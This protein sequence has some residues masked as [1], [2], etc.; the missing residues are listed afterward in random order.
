MKQ[1]E[2]KMLEVQKKQ[3]ELEAQAISNRI[4]SDVLIREELGRQAEELARAKVIPEDVLSRADLAETEFVSKKGNK[5]YKHEG[6][7]YDASGKEVSNKFIINA[8]EKGS[9]V[10]AKPVEADGKDIK[11]TS[12]MEEFNKI[13]KAVNDLLK[14]GKEPAAEPVEPTYV[15]VGD[16]DYDKPQGLYL[17]KDGTDIVSDLPGDKTQIKF[18]SKNPLKVPERLDVEHARG[19]GLTVPASSG[20]KALK[21]LIGDKE[22]SRLMKLSKK[23][24]LT[25]LSSKYPDV[26]W[27][28]FYDSYE[29]LEGYAGKLA[30]DKGYD[31]IIGD[32]DEVVILDKSI[33]EPTPLRSKNKQSG[34]QA[35]KSK[36]VE[37]SKPE[38]LTDAE[39]EAE[40]RAAIVFEGEKS[41]FFQ[42]EAKTF[43]FADLYKEKGELITE[44]VELYTGK[45]INDINRWY[46]GDGNIDIAAT[47]EML[48][49]FATRGNELREFFEDGTKHLEWMEMVSEAATWAGKLKRK[50][51]QVV[52]KPVTKLRK[53]GGGI[54]LHSGIDPTDIIK[55][56]KSVSDYVRKARAMKSFKPL[57]AAARIRRE[58]IRTLLD[59]SGNIRK[60]F[61][62]KLTDEG[63]RILQT[64]YLAKGASTRAAMNLK[65]MRKDVYR[66]LNGN[67]KRVLDTLILTDR[68]LDIAQYKTTKQF[69]FPKGMEPEKLAAYRELFGQIEKLSPERAAEIERR[70]A[71][72]FEWMKKPLQDMFEAGL[73]SEQE[74]ADLSA[75][76]YRKIKLV[77]IFDK[78]Y[79][80]KVGKKKRTVYDSG[81]EA[82]AHGRE[83]DIYEPSSEVMALEVFNRAYGR[84]MNNLANKELYNLA[85]E[86]PDNPFVKIRDKGKKNIPSGWI[87]IMLFE[88]GERKS[89]WLHPEVAKE[90]IISNP[91]M[92]YKMSQT[93]RYVSGSPVLRLFAT[94]INWGFAVANLPRDLMHAWFAARVYENG[95]WRSLYN[96]VAPVATGQLARDV[97][98]VFHDVVT[99]KG[100][101]EDYIN[102]GGGMEFLVHQGRLLQRGRHIEKPLDKFFN[103]MGWP[104]ETSELLTRLAIR[105]RA[106]RRGKSGKEA[107][108]AARDYM[109]FGQGGTVAKALDNGIPYL[110]AGIQ[111]MRGFWRALKDNPAEGIF[112]LAQFGTGVVGLYIAMQKMH[113]KT[114]EALKGNIDMQNNLCIPLGDDYA[115][116]DEYGQIRYPYFKIP[117][118]PSAKFFKKFFEASTDKWLGKEVDALEV[119]ST[120]KELS[121]VGTASLPPSISGV[122]GYWTNKDFWL[123]EDIWRETEKPFSWPASKEEYTP[124][125]PKFF[126]DVGKATGASPER[127]RYTIEELTTSGT[128]WSA[129]LGEAYEKMTE[130]VPREEKEKALAMRLAR[131]P[132]AKRFI[133]VTNPYSKHAEK[134]EKVNQEVT[135]KNFVVRRGLDTVVEGYLFKGTHTAKEVSEFIRSIPDPDMQKKM[136]DRRD[137][138]I[139]TNDLDNRSFWLRLQGMVPEARARI[140]LDEWNSA[141]EER[142]AELMQ[143]MRVVEGVGGVLTKSFWDE[144]DKFNLRQARGQ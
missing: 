12:N 28:K 43:Q 79:A 39:I 109:D 2:M 141:N 139:A 16:I 55:A 121:P 84:I 36:P 41:P 5:Y 131:M 120:L 3:L 98:S 33:V 102:E 35:P 63:Y 49:K 138:Q 110:N 92:S 115:F 83:T 116:E 22:F 105:E 54:T 135:V 103:F 29:M 93:V 87:R 20:I 90:W 14:E 107:T 58:G 101:Y 78:R 86:H 76:N 1:A 104:G 67:E 69:K 82:L 126:I 75:H 91:E 71:S 123:N 4:S 140:W 42:D 30:R 70:A 132:V 108:F 48:N 122:L 17:A 77:D 94:G 8:A 142:K 64:M 31:S 13:N 134:I 137:F 99:R 119:A 133:G 117:L 111:G 9:K 37:P 52:E 44:D 72:Y 125:T 100:R 26:K 62:A 56:A 65:Q 6:K 34:K 124:Y 127:L 51:E 15:R 81:I 10:E 46:H 80:A 32:L 45:L 144:V 88:N 73:I 66:G 95:K 40:P 129:L 61:L 19:K 74:L 7:W 18:N 59:K 57:E 53:K 89:M 136:L 143:E 118:D 38:P 96:P 24:L 27:N 23:D 21:E 113:P 47:R 130:E 50:G 128:M 114:S 97:A 85:K 112:K 68:L 106:L 25:E 60:D 11:V